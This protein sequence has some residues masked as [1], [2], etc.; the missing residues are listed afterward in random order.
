MDTAAAFL[1]AN[2]KLASREMFGNKLNI[3]SHVLP[4]IMS[5]FPWV[6]VIQ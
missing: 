4:A 2:K 3:A 5:L 1:A 6:S